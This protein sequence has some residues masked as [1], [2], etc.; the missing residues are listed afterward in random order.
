[1]SQTSVIRYLRCQK[2]VWMFNEKELQKTNQ[3]DFWVEKV[4]RKKMTNYM[5][6]GK[7]MIFPLTVGLIK[8]MSLDKSS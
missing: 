7:A 5:S 1:M 8:N 2:F 4:I 3:V 6:S